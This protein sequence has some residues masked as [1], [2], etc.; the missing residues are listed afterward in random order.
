MIF[1]KCIRL[2]PMATLS[3][4]PVCIIT[5][6][7]HRHKARSTPPRGRGIHLDVEVILDRPGSQPPQSLPASRI[8]PP[9]DTNQGFRSTYH[10]ITLIFRPHLDS[11]NLAYILFGS[12]FDD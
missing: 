12:L 6:T 7:D 2:T 11:P 8:A 9:K 3:V 5:Q 4:L 10:R 1:C